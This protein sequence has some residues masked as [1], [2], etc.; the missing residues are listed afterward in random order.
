MNSRNGHM[1]T[2]KGKINRRLNTKGNTLYEVV[3]KSDPNLLLSEADFVDAVNRNLSRGK[4]LLLIIGDG[5]KEGAASIADF[6][7]SSGH[8]N[9]TFG[10]VELTI[11]E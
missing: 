9:F 11:F 1:K 3:N 8:L 2:C 4:F 10:M 7:I 6:L 5:I